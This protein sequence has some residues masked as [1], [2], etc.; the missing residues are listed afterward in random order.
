[1]VYRFFF[2]F[3]FCITRTYYIYRVTC[4]GNITD[5]LLGLLSGVHSPFSLQIHKETRTL[6]ETCPEL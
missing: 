6:C 1:M 4:Y 3:F 5:R 2:C